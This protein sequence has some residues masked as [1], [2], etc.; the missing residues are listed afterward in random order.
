[1]D[2]L[3]A[4]LF[5]PAA[6]LVLSFAD[7]SEPG[8]G[9]PEGRDSQETAFCRQSTLYAS[10]TSE[11]TRAAYSGDGR[12]AAASWSEKVLRSPSACVFRDPDGACLDEPYTTAVASFPAIDRAVRLERSRIM[13]PGQQ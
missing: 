6:D 4:A 5:D 13:M 9:F 1:M 2:T 7:P 10:L 11:E 12:G 8:S 3:P